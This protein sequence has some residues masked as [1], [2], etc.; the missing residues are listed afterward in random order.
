MKRLR[1]AGSVLMGAII[2]AATCHSRGLCGE[3]NRKLGI[4]AG[5]SYLS[6]RRCF[7]HFAIEAR[8]STTTYE[9]TEDDIHVG[10][11]RFYITTNSTKRTMWYV[12]SEI[13]GIRFKTKTLDGYGGAGILFVGVEPA[14]TK[15]FSWMLDIGPGYVYLRDKTKIADKKTRSGNWSV[16][17]NTG[18]NIFFGGSK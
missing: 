11:G 8:Y 14:L 7:R 6:I 3:Y 18:F 17:I 16:V 12:E 5:W 4:G 1:K 2:L 9:K 13:D 15:H 10:G